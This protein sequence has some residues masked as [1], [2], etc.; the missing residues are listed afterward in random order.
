M[1]GQFARFGIPEQLITDNGPQFTSEEFKRFAKKWQFEH[2]TSSP[3]YPQSNG[4]AE[5]SVKVAKS[6]LKKAKV[7]GSDPY[8]SI[9]AFR[10][11]PT[12]GMK[13]SPVQR[14]MSKRT[15]TNIPTTQKLL[16][17]EI[18]KEAGEELRAAQ[19]RQA[20]YYNRGS[21]DLTALKAGDHIRM[22]PTG[23][24]KQSWRKAVVVGCAAQPR[25]Y[26]VRTED[27]GVYRRNR[28]HLRKTN[29]PIYHAEVDLDDIAMTPEPERDNR[30]VDRVRPQAANEHQN[31]TTRSGRRIRRPLYLRD[32]VPK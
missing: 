16:K 11:T 30:P 4:K 3:H 2:K 19:D 18:Q 7:A 27:G 1:K 26:E 25:S 24:R 28:R 21:R 6:L 13:S 12:P 22:K 29:E 32:Y 15:R 10:N 9:L 31:L 17:P 23:D 14:L 20:H 8:L 5:S